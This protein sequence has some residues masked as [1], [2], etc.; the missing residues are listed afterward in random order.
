[1]WIRLCF[2]IAFSL[3]GLLLPAVGQS[4]P[5]VIEWQQSVG[6]TSDDRPQDIQQ[7]GNGTYLILGY[8]SSSASGN[9]T[10]FGYGL[11]D[12]WLAC[13]NTNGAKLWDKAYGGS[14][15]DYGYCL[16]QTTDGGFI[17]AG[18]SS[19]PVSGNKTSTN[20]GNSDGWVLRLDGEGNKLWERSFGGTGLEYFNG[21]K[22][23][24]DGGFILVGISGSLPSGNKTSTNYGSHDGW[25]VK[26]DANGD[27]LW[28]QSYGGTG[29][30]VFYNVE[31]IQGG[32]YILGGTSDSDP[33]G[34]KTSPKYGYSDYWLVKIDAN[35]N[36]VWDK[37]FGGDGV[38]GYRL[39][40]MR[41]TSDGGYI[42]GISST[43]GISGN[44]STPNYNE[45]GSYD[46]WILRLDS[47]GDKLWENDFGGNRQDFLFNIEPTADGGFVFAGGNQADF[48]KGYYWIVRLDAQGNQVWEQLVGGG[49]DDEAIC[50]RQTSDGGYIVAGY[51][52]SGVS[53]DKT[54]PPYGGEDFWVL[55]FA[56]DPPAIGVHCSGKDFIVSWPTNAPG[57]ILQTSSDLTSSTNW[58][59]VV[60]APVV[61]GGQ[62][63]FTNS[64]SG[65]GMFYRLRR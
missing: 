44:K 21:V 56:A 50:L 43:S 27:K 65:S 25:I 51:A 19:S 3:W 54:S 49:A 2:A 5:P 18:A 15:Y 10:N 47:N 53:G 16:Q 31:Q 9:K 64:V 38:E 29:L 60:P 59:D 52:K 7:L 14:N 48:A 26:L 6:G 28:E 61:V 4:L 39:G 35:G 34:T 40:N 33:S 46:A 41:Q 62:F 45:S 13:L 22:Q 12:V 30:D 11:S 8:S 63:V 1:M 20:Y 32:D 36:K 58:V 57:F 23:I 37:S 55:K 17:V 24:S 42:V